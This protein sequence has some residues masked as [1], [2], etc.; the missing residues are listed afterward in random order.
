M[1][2]RPEL[3]PY[4]YYWD[5]PEG[6]PDGE[7]EKTLAKLQKLSNRWGHDTDS[8]SIAVASAV[9][10]A[11]NHITALSDEI[12][13]IKLAAAGGEDV[14]GS[15]NAVTAKDIV[16][17]QKDSAGLIAAQAA[18]IARL[19]EALNALNSPGT[20]WCDDMSALTETRND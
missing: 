7:I 19:R 8:I 15:A 20:D 11:I 9:E 5:R 4:V 12:Y 13:E 14:P 18:E 2:D 17:W 16:R 3:F 1:T 10:N 6:A